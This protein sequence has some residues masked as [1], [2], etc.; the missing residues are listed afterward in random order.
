MGTLNDADLR[1][2][3]GEAADDYDVPGDGPADVL[4]DEPSQR[5]LEL[6]SRRRAQL[7]AAVS[8]AAVLLVGASLFVGNSDDRVGRLAGAERGPAGSA[9]G[10]EPTSGKGQEAFVGAPGAGGSTGSTRRLSLDSDAV[11]LPVPVAAAA[12]GTSSGGS[13]AGLAPT[14]SAADGFSSSTAGS[15]AA[16]PV[17][18]APLAGDGVRVVKT[19][20]LSLVVEDG[21]VSPTLTSVQD[22]AARAGGF[23]Q[24]QTSQESGPTPSGSILLRVP[25][26]RFE[27]VVAQVRGLAVEVRTSTASGA[28]V[29]AQFTDLEAQLTTLTA[30][31][32]R[33]LSILAKADKIGDILAVQQRV[34]DVTGQ[35]DRLQGQRKLLADQSDNATLRVTVTQ[36][37]DPT[38]VTAPTDENGLA[39]A[40]QDAW[41]GFRTGVEGLIR[42]S[43]RAV[44]LLLLGGVA[45][46]AARQVWRVARRRLV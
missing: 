34:D 20:E 33:F 37:D 39:R 27:D 4:A 24:S 8:A 9:G 22:L 12:G 35:I 11:A 23:V 45:A 18:T 42:L 32:D 19:G 26:A 1:H 29:T 7:L 16:A 38:L 5:V 41:T 30:A 46:V 36:A 25:V 40:F 21:R 15:S 6:R 43:G 44:L 28:D 31:R 2:L 14:F 10:A 3:L 17:P 13:A